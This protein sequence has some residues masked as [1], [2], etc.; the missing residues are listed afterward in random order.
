MTRNEIYSNYIR[1]EEWELFRRTALRHYGTK[2]KA[3]GKFKLPQAHHINYRNLHDC[4]LDDLVILC[5]RCHEDLHRKLNAL[6]LKSSDLTRELT[7]VFARRKPR[8]ITEPKYMALLKKVLMGEMDPSKL[9]I[10][11]PPEKK[12]KKMEFAHTLYIGINF[13]TNFP[14]NDSASRAIELGCANTPIVELQDY[15]KTKYLT[16]SEVGNN[17]GKIERLYDWPPKKNQK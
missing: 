12:P 5:K 7:V 4:T 10:Y 16:D 9:P 14:I 8:G 15:L 17:L 1:S 11:S 6:G 2:C 3:C 13:K